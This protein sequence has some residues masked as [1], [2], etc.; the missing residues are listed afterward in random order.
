VY[1]ILSNITIHLLTEPIGVALI[2]PFTFG[3][4]PGIALALLVA[5]YCGSMFGGSISTILLGAPGTTS[6][7]ATLMD[8]REM[9][10][11]GK[12]GL[13]V[14]IA[15]CASTLG[16]IFGSLVLIFFC[17]PLAKVALLFGP[18]EYFA[19]GLFGLTVLSA[20]S[21]NLIMGVMSGIFGMM[22][23]SV[24]IDRLVG[25]QRYTFGLFELTSGVEFL[26]AL[27]GLFALSEMFQQ[28]SKLHET[29]IPTEE[30]KSVSAK[31]PSLAILWSLRKSITIG[32]IVG[33]IIG[34]MPGAGGAIG[35]WVA[36]AQA[37]RFSSTPEQFGKGSMEGIAAPE[38][39]NS[40][41]EGGALIPMLALGIPGSNTTAIMLGAL[42][43]QGITPGPMLFTDMPHVVYSIYLSAFLANFLVLALGIV[44]LRPV[45]KITTIP[46][47]YVVSCIIVLLFTASY[48]IKGD[49]FDLWVM[50][51]FGL[52]GFVM[53]RYKFSV[54]AVVLGMVLG[55][56]IE[57]A[58]QR[59]LMMTRGDPSVFFTRPVSL[60]FIILTVVSFAYGLYANQKQAT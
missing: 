12:S 51:F 60:A 21:K 14:G 59:S 5:S 11:L 10:K 8:G 56:M 13:A 49:M 34:I 43:L 4:A 47:H 57:L 19:L 37:Q 39:A 7:A 40:A 32:S 58:L 23:A 6:A 36:Y 48:A 38:S 42:T 50:L 2:L 15:L 24:G 52:V 35:S 46:P 55:P 1:Y 29:R 53:K 28:G 26:P 18:P 41:S 16:G 22:V 31:L 20:L 45:L 9:H 27:I 54:P 44:I 30:E 33:T 17:T 3:M 25:L